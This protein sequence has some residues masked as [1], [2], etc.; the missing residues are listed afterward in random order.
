MNLT[1]RAGRD[2]LN[3][4]RARVAS[5]RQH[6]DYSIIRVEIEKSRASPRRVR[7]RFVV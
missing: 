4:A 6:A 7:A 2:K 1:R 5:S 3:A